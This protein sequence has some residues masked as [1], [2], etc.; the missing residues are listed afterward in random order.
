VVT[1]SASGYRPREV[2]ITIDDGAP[3]KKSASVPALEAV[4]VATKPA[5]PP[6]PKPAPLP[7]PASDNRGLR[8]AALVTGIGGFVVSM[9]AGAW[10]L[11]RKGVVRDHCN[12]DKVCDGTGSDAASLG[13]ALVIVSTVAFG[14]GAIGIGGWLFLPDRSGSAGVTVG[15]N[16]P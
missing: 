11:E 15:G 2:V 5:P 1:A 7:A 13:R 12:A 3:Q 8:T 14:V 16:F 6:E 9:A 10:A 4:E